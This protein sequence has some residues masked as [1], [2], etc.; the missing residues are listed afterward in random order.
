MRRFQKKG[1]ASVGH[2]LRF[3]LDDSGLNGPQSFEVS[4]L[5]AL[6]FLFLE[7]HL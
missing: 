5:Q 7:H 6:G 2:P 3:W 4:P 1:A